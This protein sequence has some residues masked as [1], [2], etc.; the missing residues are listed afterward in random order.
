MHCL[1]LSLCLHIAYHHNT[2]FRRTNLC[3]Q[4]Q[5]ADWK[6]DITSAK[7]AKL[8]DTATDHTVAPEQHL[9]TLRGNVQGALFVAAQG[10]CVA[11]VE[12]LVK[13]GGDINARDC[14]GKT[15]LFVASEHG[16]DNLVEW[17]IEN[18]ANTSNVDLD[19]WTPAQAAARNNHNSTVEL[20]VHL[21]AGKK[22]SI[23]WQLAQ[24]GYY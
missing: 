19:G 11:E 20:F 2:R 6:D 14:N 9:I 1:I 13:R 8:N 24:V 10:G 23:I 4:A 16:H 21:G 12:Q 3:L 7:Q 15:P 17:L 22:M 5:E 18:G